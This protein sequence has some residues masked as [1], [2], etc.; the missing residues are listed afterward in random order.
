[1]AFTRSYP[2]KLT[3]VFGA[4]LGGGLILAAVAGSLSA[5]AMAAECSDADLSLSQYDKIQIGLP[6]SDLLSLYPCA[7]DVSTYTDTASRMHEVLTWTS[8]ERSIS[9]SVDLVDSNVLT[10]NAYGLKPSAPQQQAAID[11]HVSK[12]CAAKVASA[13]EP[14]LRVWRLSAGLPV[15]KQFGDWARR[16]DWGFDW[17][18]PKTWLVPADLEIRGSFDAAISQAVQ[19]LYDQGKP[20]RLHIWEGNC[21]AEVINADTK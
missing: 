1:M 12:P 8:G 3:E 14:S 10:K 6:K 21:Y 5:P 17:R 2:K 20:I 16:A 15:S 9:V 19:M 7:A 18:P 13:V 4:A 11:K